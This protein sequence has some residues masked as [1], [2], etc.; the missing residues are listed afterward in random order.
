MR[1]VLNL[2][3]KVEGFVYP[4]E[5]SLSR[6]LEHDK[7]VTVSDIVPSKFNVMS[8]G[9]SLSC[10]SLTHSD[11][12]N[13][14]SR[15]VKHALGKASEGLWN[16]MNNLGIANLSK[17]FDPIKRLEDMERRCDTPI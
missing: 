2:G 16:F 5:P 1:E 10:D 6:N 3:E 15:V 9:L 17:D 12:M 14:K 7:L 8:D 13:C 11:V 4:V